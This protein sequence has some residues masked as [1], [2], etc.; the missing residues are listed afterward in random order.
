MVIFD[1]LD[2]DAGIA[3]YHTACFGKILVLI[4]G[5]MER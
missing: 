3:H 4:F 5:R 1:R 2:A